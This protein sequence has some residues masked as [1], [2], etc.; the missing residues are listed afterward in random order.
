MSAA[1]G[2]NP[3]PSGRAA[4]Q[5]SLVVWQGWRLELPA[6]WHPVKIE[7]TR[8]QGIA[9]FADLYQPRLGLQ[10]HTPPRR[11]FDAL[12][13]ARR[14]MRDEVG[15]LAAEEAREH[16][17]PNAQWQASLLYQ[18]P[19]PPGRD[20]WV[21]YSPLSGRVI[22]VTRHVRHRDQV[23]ARSILPA[24]GDSR[25]EQE[26]G[27]AIFELSCRTPLGFSLQSQKLM[28]GDLGLTFVSGRR[29]MTVRQI[30][31]AS[32]ALQRMPLDGWVGEQ[33]RAAGKHYKPSG[34][35][36]DL[37]LCSEDGRELVGRQRRLVRRR[38]F[39]FQRWLAPR[40]VTWALHDPQRDRLVI[41]QATD[42]DLAR[43]IAATVGWAQV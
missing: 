19:D 2:V 15:K 6:K 31:V 4:R 18:D 32:L 3:A 21:A 28:A 11:R 8:H 34:V 26:Q 16:A 35:F 29:G 17:V 27:W 7:G 24:L 1:T 36:S 38:R 12:S 5:R 20:V 14:A 25:P 41:V 23:L 22:K 42:D 43:Q 9:L 30:A 13:W 10:W 40:F 37:S 39:V 33:Q